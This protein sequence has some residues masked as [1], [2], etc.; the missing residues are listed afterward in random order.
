MHINN[1]RIKHWNCYSSNIW[2]FIIDQCV[3]L[4]FRKFNP[5]HVNVSRTKY[6]NRLHLSAVSSP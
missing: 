5:V 6:K 1:L 4:L 2:S 3:I